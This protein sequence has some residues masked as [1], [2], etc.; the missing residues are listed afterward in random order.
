MKKFHILIGLVLLASSQIYS[1][2]FGGF[3]PSVKWKQINTDTARIIFPSPVD[4]LAQDIA[5]IVHKIM[6]QRPNTLGDEVRKINIVLHNNTT[7][8]NGY[9]ALG[10]YR[11][12][13]YLIPGSDI[14]EFGA[15]P[16]YKELGVH[17]F[18]HALQYSNFNRGI[19]KIGSIIFEQEGQALFNALLIPG[20]F[21]E[22]DAVHSETSVTTQG[23]ART[24][25]FFKGYR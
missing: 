8:A 7:L 13:F 22:G 4:S 17:E 10:P 18:R 1:Q 25:D 12:E 16:W 14:F 24:R 2:Q 9:V 11:S 19:S 5:A 3:P 21:W 20:W 23:R 6:M 15:N